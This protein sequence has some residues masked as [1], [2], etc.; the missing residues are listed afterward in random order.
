MT[1]AIQPSPETPQKHL[2]PVPPAPIHPLAALTTI[3]LDNVFGVI[4][5][6][7]PL[8]LIFTSLTVGGVGF[9]TTMMVQRHLAK[10]EWGAAAAKGL[11]MG[12][13]AGVPFQVTGTAV[14]SILLGWAGAN[15]WI[16]LPGQRSA[17]S[18]EQEAEIVEAQPLETEK[19]PPG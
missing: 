9:L 18:Q 2:S 12:V 5:I 13:L 8:A 4:E 15:R 10:D 17:P 16:R 7:D 1:N 3:V 14:G 6:V 19:K 11:V